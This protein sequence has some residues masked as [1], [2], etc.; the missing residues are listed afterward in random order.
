MAH[1]RCEDVG[2]NRLIA[3]GNQVLDD[4][5]WPARLGVA[6]RHIGTGMTKAE[7]D[8]LCLRLNLSEL[9]AYRT[10]ITQRTEEVMVELASDE[11][12]H[13]LTPK[14]LQQVFVEEGAGGVAADQLFELYYGHTKGWLLGHLAL[15]HNYYHIGQAF[16]ARA[17]Y[18]C[19]IHG[20][21]TIN[22]TKR[23]KV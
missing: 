21:K 8:E 6:L 7:V 3:D 16:A 15:T 2:I 20:N 12:L 22:I 17:M 13:E 18:G 5:S 1:A 11:L 4:G 23:S 14:R 10:C 9:F 19:R